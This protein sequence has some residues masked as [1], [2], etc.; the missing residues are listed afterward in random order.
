MSSARALQLSLSIGLVALLAVLGGPVPVASGATITAYSSFGPGGTFDLFSSYAILGA[1]VDP[2]LTRELQAASFVPT[3]GGPLTQVSLVMEFNT[4]GTN[5]VGLSLVPDV[6]GK[7]GTTPLETWTFS[8]LDP[9]VV[10][11]ISPGVTG[12]IT[13]AGNGAALVAG[14]KYWLV[15]SPGAADT[16]V[17]WFLNDSGITAPHGVQDNGGA[18]DVQTL[19]Q[20]VFSV[21]VPEPAT[22]WVMAVGVVGAVVGRRRRRRRLA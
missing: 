21:A 8:A 17:S 20:P 4:P 19:T 3:H 2:F 12:P 5:T 11:P 15:A 14:Q 10:G 18:W 9:A 7:P 22:L 6:G 1:G 13:L 16:W